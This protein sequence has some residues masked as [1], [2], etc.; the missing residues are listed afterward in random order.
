MGPACAKALRAHERRLMWIE[1][2]RARLKRSA[3]ARPCLS[4]GSVKDF[5]LYSESN[6]NSRGVT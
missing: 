4:Y 6:M 3:K 1:G 5:V 2:W